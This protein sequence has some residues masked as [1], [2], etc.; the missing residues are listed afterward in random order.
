MRRLRLLRVQP[1]WWDG[2]TC[3]IGTE[4]CLRGTH[5][6]INPKPITTELN[7]VPVVKSEA[8]PGCRASLMICA[9]TCFGLCHFAYFC[10][11]YFGASER[12]TASGAADCAIS[13]RDISQQYR[14]ASA[15]RLQSSQ[16]TEK[17]WTVM[18]N[19]QAR[20]GEIN[21]YGSWRTEHELL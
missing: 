9:L 2:A 21:A 20:D 14:A 5:K 8:A 18:A 15:T 16:L 10:M 19:H 3:W 12:D 11:K 7:I 13:S 4:T 1:I 6:K 17:N